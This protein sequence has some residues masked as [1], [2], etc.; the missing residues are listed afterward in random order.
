MMATLR[1]KEILLC[2]GSGIWPWLMILQVQ[3]AWNKVRPNHF[4]LG[5]ELSLDKP[6]VYWV[7]WLRAKAQ[8]DQWSEEHILIPR[9]MNW[10]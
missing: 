5:H 10:T 7:N 3:H 2:H 4:H 1:V 8:Y 6:T 9:K